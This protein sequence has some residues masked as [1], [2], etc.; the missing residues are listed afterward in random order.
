MTKTALLAQF[1][2]PTVRTD[3]LKLCIEYDDSKDHRQ[4]KQGLLLV[5]K[6]M[7]ATQISKV[8]GLD[9]V[10][11]YRMLAPSG[12]PSFLSVSKLCQALGVRVWVVDQ[13]FMAHRQPKPIR[14]LDLPPDLRS[15]L[16]KLGL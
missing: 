2:N 6:A 13:D 16:K 10:N 11:L 7:G 14:R 5:V 15:R 4:F 12:N 3:F 9:R 8:T 1:R